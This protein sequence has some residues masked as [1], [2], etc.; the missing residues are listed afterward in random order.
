MEAGEKMSSFFYINL[1]SSIVDFIF[2][3]L[4]VRYYIYEENIKNPYTIFTVVTSLLWNMTIF[5]SIFHLEMVYGYLL[6]IFFISFQTIPI[7]MISYGLKF[8]YLYITESVIFT[9]GL[10]FSI[11][12]SAFHDLS[13]MIGAIS[14][15]NVI[16]AITFLVRK[17]YD[18]VSF[19]KRSRIL[20]YIVFYGLFS[21]VE[22]ILSWLWIYKNPA[23]TYLIMMN[24]ILLPIYI[25]TIM[26]L[27]YEKQITRIS[28]S[29]LKNVLYGAMISSLISSVIIISYY[30]NFYFSK[31]SGILQFFFMAFIVI[32][33]SFIVFGNYLQKIDAF[34]EYHL[35][36]GRGYKR[37]QT[38]G[39]VRKSL[40][41]D[42]LEELNALIV[43][44]CSS[45]INTADVE[46]FFKTD[47]G[48]FKSADRE[49]A[50]SEM[51]YD[52]SEKIVDLYNVAGSGTLSNKEL[53]VW[54]KNAD[55]VEGLMV[56]GHKKSGKYS[57]EDL[58][59]IDTLS[60]HVTFFLSRYRSIQRVLQIEQA[61]RFQE[62]MA[63]L[64]KLSSG[65]THEIRNPLNIIST[66]IQM[67]KNNVDSEKSEKLWKYIEE[68]LVRV[69]SI[70]E[71]FLY[72]ARQ[73][74]P[75]IEE[76]DPSEVVKKISLLLAENASKRSIEISVNIPS[77]PFT[78]KFDKTMLMEILLNLGTN[79]LEAAE[80]G[81]AVEFN[82][83]CTS[84]Y[85]KISVSNSGKMIP[86]SELQH[87]FE[88]FYTTKENGTGLGL[89]IVY[90]Y[91][92]AMGGNV[93]V[94]SDENKTVFSILIPA[95]VK[96]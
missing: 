63:A 83:E 49:I 10:I 73:K 32:F 48:N 93:D 39:F 56:L 58:E 64:G 78:A 68:E 35:R 90:S 30:A 28:M 77:V 53:I 54:M 36:T 84:K 95:E 67:L 96:R 79:A 13:F 18:V 22:T 80:D 88:P 71:N 17:Y 81:G 14:T 20:S 52:D 62:R 86:V 75:V 76:G 37:E 1:A 51:K 34:F 46:L 7:L 9:I 12:L 82:V 72:F 2:L 38:L 21:V 57:S 31:S 26:N 85:F 59:W 61:M 24:S 42:S 47:A 27:V 45:V 4:A 65:V 33:L 25:Y 23:W 44:Y 29:F 70:L 5:F 60:N 55:K 91:V 15:F 11:L 66:S 40:E 87:I 69:N 43:D 19:T 92:N 8:K 89:S 16:F 6:P 41:I 3:W 50:A 74:P 94:K